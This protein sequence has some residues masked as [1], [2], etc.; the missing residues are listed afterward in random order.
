MATFMDSDRPLLLDNI[1]FENLMKTNKSIYFDDIKLKR[2]S[3]ILSNIPYNMLKQSYD[4]YQRQVKINETTVNTVKNENF[5]KEKKNQN[6]NN[7]DASN[8]AFDLMHE[9]MK[10][11]REASPIRFAY[12]K[13]NE[14]VIHVCDEAKQL[15]RDFTC[16][17]DLLIKE[18]KYFSYNINLG[19]TNSTVNSSNSTNPPQS[20]SALAK[21]T[22]DDM[23]ISVHCDINIFDWL[24]KYVKRYMIEDPENDT[25]HNE[26]KDPKLEIT[27]CVSIL[28]SSDFLI[29]P[30]LVDKCIKYMIDN[31]NQILQIPCNMNTIND[32]LITKIG[33]FIKIHS[34]DELI[35]KK[36]KFKAKLFMKK[37]EFLFDVAKFKSQF[38]KNEDLLAEHIVLNYYDINENDCA[39]LFRCKIC[40]RIMT[41]HGSKFI[42]CKLGVLDKNGNYNYFHVSDD[43]FDL[44]MFVIELKDKLKSWQHVFWF[45]WALI[46]CAKCQQCKDWFRFVD[47]NKCLVSSQ[48]CSIHGTKTGY[49]PQKRINCSCVYKDHIFDQTSFQIFYSYKGL[50]LSNILLLNR[51]L[52]DDLTKHKEII[53][54]GNGIISLQNVNNDGSISF[55]NLI[56][57]HFSKFNGDSNQQSSQQQQNQMQSSNFFI[58]SINGKHISFFDKYYLNLISLSQNSIQNPATNINDST[59]TSI[60]V[61]TSDIN[62]YLKLMQNLDPLNVFN[63]QEVLTFLKADLKKKW[64]QAKPARWNQD[65]Q[66]EDDMIRFR[67]IGSYILKMRFA[68]DQIILNVANKSKMAQNT[69]RNNNNANTNLNSLNFS[70]VEPLPSGYYFRIENEWKARLSTQTTGP[71]YST[72]TSASSTINTNSS[73]TST[74]P[75]ISYSTQ[76][77]SNSANLNSNLFNPISGNTNYNNV[78]KLRQS[79]AQQPKFN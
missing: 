79:T 33:A 59:A 72:Q 53:C 57:N 22:L 11:E 2:L 73:Q 31:M 68:Y 56:E 60:N 46:K 13:S 27:N 12:D 76:T 50:A 67:E 36:D 6:S 54:Y 49:M 45:L 52:V 23:D 38:D 70:S 20:S 71:N 42:K 34:L 40:G 10:K 4:N 62:F 63:S 25:P 14:I 75:P 47:Y 1:L 19:T 37:I 8:E 7:A 69:N 44:N 77:G 3:T 74:Q 58:D 28:I 17:R 15:K 18:M 51:H 35:D 32:K 65:N 61:L 78:N 24:M 48:D 43:K 55:C 9:L 16:P 21:R 5:Q 26:V 30:D 66:R 64:D 39:T 29:M 41:Q